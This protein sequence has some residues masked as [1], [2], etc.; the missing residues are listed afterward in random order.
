MIFG[1]RQ[2]GKST[3]AREYAKKKAQIN[4]GRVIEINFFEDNKNKMG[5]GG[6]YAGIFNS[7]LNPSEILNRISILKGEDIDVSKDILLLD[8]I[9]DCI[10]AYESLKNF[11]EVF[12]GFPVMAS[13]SYLQLFLE[14]GENIRHSVG[15]T[16]EIYLHPLTFSEFLHNL[17][18][19]LF[20]AYKKISRPDTVIDETAHIKFIEA[21]EQY[22]FTG[23]M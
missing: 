18:V 4:N 10:S 8:E 11:K 19:P 9:Q 5:I 14:T 13:G 3:L 1:P 15:C 7:S 23:G 22:L 20:E 12:P 17:N 16:S 2:V 6:R 21:F